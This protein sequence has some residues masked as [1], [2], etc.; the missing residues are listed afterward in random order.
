MQAKITAKTVAKMKPGDTISDTEIRGFS[1][2]RWDTRA[3]TYSLR[4]RTRNGD[5]KRLQIGT[6]GNVTPDEARKIAKQR[7]GEVAGGHDP[8]AEQKAAAAITGKTVA[9]IWDE[10]AKRELVKKRSA[11]EQMRAFDRLV[12]PRIGDRSIYELRRSDMVKLL[13]AIEDNHGRVMGDRML[14]Y[15]SACFRWQQVRDEDFVSPIITGMMRTTTK[16]LARDRVL[17]DDEIRAIWKATGE[18]IFGALVRFLLLTAARRSEA[19]EMTWTELDGATWTLPAARNKVKVELVRPLS[20]AALAILTALPRGNGTAYVFAG[21][22]AAFNSHDRSKKRFDLVSGVTGWRLHDL[23]RTARS[24]MSRA[25]V[26]SDHA[27]MC[28]GHTL[29]GVR[30]TYD[31]HAYF[32]EKASAFER[33]ADLV[34]AI[35]ST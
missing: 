6:H 16:E 35:V 10:Y 7:A 29:R 25:G 26:P 17:T 19:A 9:V 24:L 12:R 2:R 8:A 23:R 13:D 28:L 5:R 34:A 32:A 30:A 1:A 20:K 4:Y 22:N 31:R 14:A 3:I 27:E 18:G 15:L 33:L 21:R 11:A